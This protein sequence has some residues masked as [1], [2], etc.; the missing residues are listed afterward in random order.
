MGDRVGDA[1]DRGEAD[2]VDL[3]A[4]VA[5]HGVDNQRGQV[6]PRKQVA[7]HLG[8]V[9]PNHIPLGFDPR[10]AVIGDLVAQPGQELGG[11]HLVE[12]QLA[13]VV[14]QAGGKGRRGLHPGNQAVL[15]QALGDKRRAERMAPELVC[16]ERVRLHGNGH[17]AADAQREDNAHDLL[18]ADQEHGLV[19]GGDLL[20]VPVERRVAGP[21]HLRR[22]HAV[23][24]QALDHGVVVLVMLAQDLHQLHAR[25]GHRLEAL[26]AGDNVV[27]VHIECVSTPGL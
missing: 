13:D 14:Q 18:V 16:V 24:L 19:H 1:K 22:E 3:G 6:P 23:V 25:A 11:E 5:R 8:V 20:A 27:R 26:Q 12:G 4:V 15:G 21:Q 2:R 9:R 10:H 17:G 7:A